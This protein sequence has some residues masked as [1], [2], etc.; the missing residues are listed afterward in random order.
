[1]SVQAQSPERTG[2]HKGNLVAGLSFGS[3]QQ[4][5]DRETSLNFTP[6]L[7]YFVANHWSIAL[8]GRYEQKKDSYNRYLGAGLS[9]RYYTLRAHRL[10]LFGQASATL[11]QTR[12]HDFF[13]GWCGTGLPSD[14]QSTRY[15]SKRLDLQTA[16]SAGTQYA[17]GK[18]LSMEASIE[19]VLFDT[20]T[21]DAYDLSCGTINGAWRAN[22]GINYRLR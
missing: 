8:D 16:L 20:R 1:M 6:R 2:L 15:H 3:G 12:D 10:S 11:G 9:T 21:G 17:L 19:R 14:Y 5:N 18:R 7:Q 22:V 13:W 4:A